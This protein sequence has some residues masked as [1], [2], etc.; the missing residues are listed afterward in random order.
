MRFAPSSGLF[1]FAIFSAAVVCGCSV[2]DL[3]GSFEVALPAGVSQVAQR[4]SALP[5]AAGVAWQAFRK[6]DPA[7]TAT[8]DK[9]TPGPYGGLLDGG[10]LER[11]PVDGQIFI[12]EFDEEG[13]VVATREN[14]YLLPEVYGEDIRIGGDWQPARIPLLDFKTAE[15]SVQVDDKYGIA[16]LVHVRFGPLYVGRAIIYSWGTVLDQGAD[17]QFG[18]RLDFENG[19]AGL[20]LESTGDQYPFY[21]TEVPGSK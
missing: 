16:I 7:P 13:R 8:V 15:Y 2:P 14:K 20:I 12:A 9:A 10:F 6:A 3:P 4:G 21:A 19:L 11:P 1:G 17:G 18:Y 5:A